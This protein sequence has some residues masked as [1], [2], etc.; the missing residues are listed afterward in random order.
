MAMSF[1]SNFTRADIRSL[2]RTCLSKDCGLHSIYDVSIWSTSLEDILTTITGIRIQPNDN[3]PQSICDVCKEKAENAY[4]F[5]RKSQESDAALQNLVKS[6]EDSF[7]CDVK[8]NLKMKVK[9]EALDDPEAAYDDMDFSTLGHD[10]DDDDNDE[11]TK[12]S[13]LDPIKKEEP[14]DTICNIPLQCDICTKFFKSE[15]ALKDHLSICLRV[16]CKTAE[17]S[18][19]PICGVCYTSARVLTRHM[20]ASHA[21][22]VGPRRRGRPSKPSVTDSIL[23]DLTKKGL[24]VKI[25]KP[26]GCLFC[27]EKFKLKED[28]A[29]HLKDHKDTKVF[30]CTG[31]KRM[32]LKLT[33][34]E[35]HSCIE[36]DKNEE[37]KP[38]VELI[39]MKEST[40]D[41]EVKPK[42]LEEV[43]LHTLVNAKCAPGTLLLPT[44][45][46]HCKEVLFSDDDLQAHVDNCHPH[47]SKKCTIC[48]KQFCS[49]KTAAKHRLNCKPV[50]RSYS[51]PTCGDK[52]A[53]EITL[54]KHI[55]K[56]HKGQSIK[57]MFID[58]NT[59]L[60]LNYECDTC[61]RVFHNKQSLIKH[62]KLHMPHLEKSYECDVCQKRFSRKDN[63]KSHRRVHSPR[64]VVKTNTCLCLYCGRSFNNSSNLIVHMRRHT[65]EK[66]YK[67]DFCGKGF[68]RSSDLQCHRRSHTGEKPCVCKVCNKAF[69]RSNK[70]S[71]HMRIHTGVKPY[72][73]TYCEK[74]F[75]QS[76]DL[77]LHVRRHTG[78]KP[79][80]C[81]VCGDRFIQGTA[82]ASHRRA[83]GHFPNSSLA[84]DPAS[85]P[86]PFAPAPP[87]TADHL[88]IINVTSDKLLR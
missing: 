23:D 58:T 47:K 62:T 40:D 24:F 72:K 68:P 6:N 85:A 39:K 59:K 61:Q 4:D 1:G 14:M 81:D 34:F 20:H 46:E 28:V 86:A 12:E 11:A 21:G 37:T 53:Y 54:N 88:Q 50:E 42:V 19:C 13:R 17:A 44:P 5:K 3:M 87:A 33:D 57:V 51:C 75:S 64:R 27:D 83:H 8:P 71:R 63:M 38:L 30:K 69:S 9:E 48:N 35:E 78:D 79:Y 25:L 60:E 52:F 70:L 74:A 66:P 43:P 73:C 84:P 7:A 82:L 65:G 10:D 55:L 15:K 36:D 26:F 22:L 16:E 77:T 41:A 67:C 31:C 45:C 2:C 29:A 18:Y 56:T 49:L 80:I 76:N 32:Y